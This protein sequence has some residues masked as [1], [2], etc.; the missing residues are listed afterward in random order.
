MRKIGHVNNSFDG[1]LWDSLSAIKHA[2]FQLRHL[3]RTCASPTVLASEI[4]LCEVLLD[5]ISGI[6]SSLA[7]DL[8]QTRGPPQ[9]IGHAGLSA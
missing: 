5:E 6:R 8:K 2:R 7:K 4:Q 3:T 9:A 1:A